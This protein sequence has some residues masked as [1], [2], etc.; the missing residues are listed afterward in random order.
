[1]LFLLDEDVK[2][3][4]DFINACRYLLIFSNQK[5]LGCIRVFISE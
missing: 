4:D 5:N 1:L 2:F 3:S